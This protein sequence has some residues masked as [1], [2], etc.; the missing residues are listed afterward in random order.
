MIEITD[1]IKMEFDTILREKLIRPVYQPIVSLTDG[2]I[3]GYE[4][5]SRITLEK[6]SFNVE[7]MFV[8]ATE[9]GK[10]WEL[11]ELCRKESLRFAKDKRLDA[12][13][14][15]NVD[16]NI[17]H[18]KEFKSG[19]T[20][21][22]LKQYHLEPEDIV[23]EITERS[24]IDDVETFQGTI[25]HYKQQTF[26]TA[27]DDFGNG[28]AGLNRVCAFSPDFI[29]F[30]RVVVENIHLNQKKKALVKSCLQFCKSEGIKA[31]AEG[32]EKEEE[33]ETLIKIGIDYGQ[34][35]FIQ[36]PLYEKYDIRPELK[37][38]IIS[39]YQKNHNYKFK[40]SFFGKVG[41][42]CHE[43]Q[44]VFLR[45]PAVK[46]FEKMERNI[47]LTEMFVLDEKFHVK[48]ILT[49]S[50]L[51]EG[52]G[53]RYGFNLHIRKTAEE[54]MDHD[55]LI[56]DEN[57]SVE[58]VSKMAL[59][60]SNDCIYDAVVVTQ[61]E[62]YKGVVT[63]K[64]LLET[65]IT[66]QVTKAIDTN[67]L[68]GLPGNTNIQK[69]IE[70]TIK[71][72]K[73]YAVIYFDLDNFKAYNDAYGFHNG[74]MMIKTMA[75]ILGTVSQSK[76]FAGHIGGDDFVLIVKDWN[77]ES[78]CMG[79]M[80]EFQEKIRNLYSVKD[81]ENGFIISKNRNG[82]QEI[83]PIATISAAVV[84]NEKKQIQ[85]MTDLSKELALAKKEAKQKKGNSI[86]KI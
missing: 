30:D 24:A 65:A 7:Q 63:V 59:A 50:S 86:F 66:I 38:Q 54:M 33:L 25:E 17:I 40:P 47:G 79:I 27:I 16:P 77:V 57:V 46:V 78:I 13:I 5:L 34:G 26:L 37:K 29:K 85:S 14:F 62:K 43:K 72:C 58:T 18:D 51:L 31:I 70:E 71:K 68:T 19:M 42:I 9:T 52:F 32:I 36:R 12:K 49:R 3:L 84:T 10:L 76:M 81:W 39:V 55:F 2:S 48:G 8:F 83:F 82:F 15:L 11:E 22:Y 73:K 60:R 35:Y 80:K 1:K 56:V 69:E 53:G 23:F 6:C 4:A 44:T 20:I 74:D 28:Y 67:P 41:N 61:K 21:E 64:D 45:E 75:T